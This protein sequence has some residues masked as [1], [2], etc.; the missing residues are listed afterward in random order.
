MRYRAVVFDFDGTLVDSMDYVVNLHQA[1]LKKTGYEVT[2][3]QVKNAGGASL[4][5]F[6]RQIV[7]TITLKQILKTSFHLLRLSRKQRE[8]FTLFP[9]VLKLLET[10][11][12]NRVKLAVVT[13]RHNPKTCLKRARIRKYFKL[14]VGYG[15]IR[16]PKPHPDPF[17]IVAHKL[18]L[19]PKDILAVGDSYNDIVSAR[20]AGCKTVAFLSGTQ[21]KAFLKKARPDYFA[22]T[23]EDILKIALG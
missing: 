12:M 9:G 2:L 18:H 17:Q 21:R 8:A 11:R 1:A 22:K 15:I 7:P 3:Q 23:P 4:N 19:L 6:Y 13:S 5:T 10:L 16:R 20:R 14:V